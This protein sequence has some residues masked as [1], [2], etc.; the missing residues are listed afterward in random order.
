MIVVPGIE[1]LKQTY[2]RKIS[3]MYNNHRWMIIN[4]LILQVAVR[5]NQWYIL[6][7]LVREKQIR[8]GFV[9]LFVCKETMRRWYVAC[10]FSPL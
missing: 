10:S 7:R 6:F 1:H 5:I 9:F 4:K 8:K 2:K 3:F